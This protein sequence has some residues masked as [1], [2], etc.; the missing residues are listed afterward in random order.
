[1]MI[2]IYELIFHPPALTRKDLWR[3]L[4]RAAVVPA[5]GA[6]MV[7]LNVFGR[8]LAAEGISHQGGYGMTVSAAEY[9]GKTAGYL[10]Q[11]FFVQPWFT[12]GG[13]AMFLLAMLLL[14]WGSKAALYCWFLFTAGILPMAFI[15]LRGL[16]AIYIPVAGLMIFAAVLLVRTR[17]GVVRLAD[18]L[19]KPGQRKGRTILGL[20]DAKAFVLFM[21]LALFLFR[22]Y[23]RHRSSIE[24]WLP[25]HTHIR[26]VIEQWR[27]LHPAIPKGG[28]VLILQD[29][30][31]Q[32]NWA[33]AFI[34]QLIY[35]EH[36]PIDRLEQMDPKPDAKAIAEY[37]YVMTYE[38]GQLRDAR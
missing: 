7:L 37:T 10:D 34:G 6:A 17:D 33:S 20:Y 4:P 35:R 5:L 8:V 22:T 11:F 1:L 19:R 3:W 13:A 30:F 2:A 27:R 12:R 32:Y 24:P 21:A 14:A 38:D 36:V 18:R 31:G 25:E 15:S 29:P 16:T 9:V 28:R 23:S 26:G